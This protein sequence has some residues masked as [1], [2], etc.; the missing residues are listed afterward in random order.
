[1][2]PSP[3]DSTAKT[4]SLDSGESHRAIKGVRLAPDKR[5]RETAQYIADMILELRNMAKA[6]DL[7]HV[8]VPLEYAYYEAFTVAN[9]VEPPPGEVERLKAL[10]KEAEASE[11]QSV[12][13]L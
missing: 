9:R 6:A 5:K 2:T 11:A 13:E 10:A 1:M 8:M 3:A 4:T 7:A 12:Q